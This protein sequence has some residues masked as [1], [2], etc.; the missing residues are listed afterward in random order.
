MKVVPLFLLLLALLSGSLCAGDSDWKIVEVKAAKGR[1]GY[2]E[3]TVCNASDKPI[4]IA[5]DWRFGDMAAG[6]ICPLPPLDSSEER[7]FYTGPNPTLIAEPCHFTG[8]GKPYM[9]IE[10]GGSVKAVL[11]SLDSLRDRGMRLGLV[12]REKGGKV[13]VGLLEKPK[14]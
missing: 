1:P 7:I 5:R 12:L 11:P 10:P 3:V 6:N 9:K 14:P 2:E 13:L 8:G 4:E